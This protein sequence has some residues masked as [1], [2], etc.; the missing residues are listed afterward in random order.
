MMSSCD[1]R[2]RRDINVSTLESE[3]VMVGCPG[4]PYKAIRF[5][6]NLE[7]TG[8][9]ITFPRTYS[10]FVVI[11]DYSL[12]VIYRELNTVD[13]K[14][15]LYGC[16]YYL[17]VCEDKKVFFKLDTNSHSLSEAFGVEENLRNMEYIYILSYLASNGATLSNDMTTPLGNNYNRNNL[18]YNYNP[19]SGNELSFEDYIIYKT[20][21]NPTDSSSEAFSKE[22]TLKIINCYKSCNKC[23]AIADADSHNCLECKLPSDLSIGENPYYFLD[24]ASSK[25]LAYVQLVHL[26]ILLSP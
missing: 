3:M 5:N 18:Y 4:E 9:E 14:Y 24:D 15:Y 2:K 26:T 22:C 7:K 19:S 6:I 23:D 13:N 25:I 12:F 10:E 1:D 11:N 16:I 21:I 8:S 17:P 20:V